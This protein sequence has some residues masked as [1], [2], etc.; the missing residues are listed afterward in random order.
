MV[1]CTALAGGLLFGQTG[2]IGGALL[3]S[4]VFGWPLWAW[5]VRRWRRWLPER[6]RS[7]G[8]LQRLAV[9]TGLIGPSGSAIEQAERSVRVPLMWGIFGAGVAALVAFVVLASKGSLAVAIA[10]MTVAS[11][12]LAGGAAYDRRR[13]GSGMATIAICASVTAAVAWLLLPRLPVPAWIAAGT[14]TLTTVFALFLVGLLAWLPGGGQPDRR[15][16]TAAGLVTIS[17]VS[18]AISSVSAGRFFVQPVATSKTSPIPVASPAL[19]ATWASFKTGTDKPH[20]TLVDGLQITDVEPGTGSGAK[21]G[22]VLT[23]RYIMWLSDGRQVFSS[24]AAGQPFTFTLGTGEVLLGWDEG[25]PGMT[26]GG[27]RRLVI[28]PA[29]AYGDGGTVDKSSGIYVVPPNTTLV[30]IVRLVSIKPAA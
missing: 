10:S 29:L 5:A 30:F 20:Q 19:V 18:V 28:P 1:A 25:V 13:L 24:D 17:L 11:L 21:R 7:S 9:A 23:V 22:D 6:S 26:A 12:C 4:C 8:D 15:R 14:V 3:G 27:T 16:W 2:A